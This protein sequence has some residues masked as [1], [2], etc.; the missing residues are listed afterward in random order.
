[1]EKLMD[2]RNQ[3]P[4]IPVDGF[5]V[6]FDTLFNI[7]SKTY[8]AFQKEKKTNLGPKS[9]SNKKSNAIIVI[10]DPTYFYVDTLFN[11]FCKINLA[12]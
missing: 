1:M 6:Y 2:I 7:S 8:L 12:L 9:G 5:P 4:T 10:S 3:Q 11:F